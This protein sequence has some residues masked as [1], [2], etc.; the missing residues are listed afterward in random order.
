I[1]DFDVSAFAKAE[2][3]VEVL[4]FLPEE[5]LNFGF[6]WFNVTQIIVREFCFFGDI[7]VKHPSDY[8]G[9]DYENQSTGLQ[10]DMPALFKI[11]ITDGNG[12]PVPHSPFSNGSADANWGI[13]APL[14]VQYPDNLQE[15]GEKFTFKLYILV[16]Q[17]SGFEYK[18]FATFTATDDGAL[19]DENGD[20]IPDTG[21]DGIIDFVLGSCNYSNTDVQLPPYQNLPESCTLMIESTWGPAPVSG[22]Y[23][24]AI[25]SGISGSG[26]DLTNGTYGSYCYDRLTGINVRPNYYTMDIYSTLY[27]SLMPL[28]VQ[29]EDWDRLN[30]LI[31][32]LGDY[33]W[34]WS[35]LQQVI[36]K[37]EDPSWPGTAYGGCNAITSVGIDMYND[38]VANGDGYVP[39]PGGWAAVCFVPQGTPP[40]QQNPVLQTVFVRV[41]P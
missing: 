1:F 41:D 30:W 39:L 38:A 17:G 16:K 10:I 15:A 8:E 25:I 12:D 40:D 37:L 14:C 22:D 13:G 6:D 34:D 7:C 32:H 19:V 5:Y 21:Q 36:W 29:E 9:S 2:V 33:A 20:P 31:N 18:Y 23:M 3:P 27:P 28:Y 24:D 26:Y 35:D 11:E 4:C